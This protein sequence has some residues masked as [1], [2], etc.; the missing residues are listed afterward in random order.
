[1]FSSLLFDFAAKQFK[2]NAKIIA[3]DKIIDINFF[4]FITTNLY[5]ILVVK[6]IVVCYND[7]VFLLIIIL[8]VF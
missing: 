2:G 3:K 1:M 7:L 6:M 5:S 4:I 8:S